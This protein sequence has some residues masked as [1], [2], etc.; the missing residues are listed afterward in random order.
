MA[1]AAAKPAYTAYAVAGEGR[2]ANWTRIGAAWA[3]D[4]GEGFNIVITPGIAVSGKLVL[5]PPK[6]QEETSTK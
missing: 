4:D 3:H 2:N 5:R 1:K 6:S